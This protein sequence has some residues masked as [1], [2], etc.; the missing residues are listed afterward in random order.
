VIPAL[1]NREAIVCGE[2]VPIPVRLAFDDL[3]AHRRP[4]S[5]DPSFSALWATPGG[6]QALVA[7]TVQRWR[8]HGK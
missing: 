5:D 7:R 1:R 2:G 4:A 6:E 3:E 8:S